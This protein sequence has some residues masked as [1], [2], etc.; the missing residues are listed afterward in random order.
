MTYVPYE[1]L[2]PSRPKALASKTSV[3]ADS[4]SRACLNTDHSESSIGAAATALVV[5][6]PP[7]YESGASEIRAE[8]ILLNPPCDLN[9]AQLHE[10]GFTQ[11]VVPITGL[12]P[13]RPCGH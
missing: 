12:E 9:F 4:T 3:S 5:P 10:S 6:R 13:A 7:D 2:E 1:G 8:G 11:P